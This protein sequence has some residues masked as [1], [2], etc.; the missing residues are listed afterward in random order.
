MIRFNCP[1]CKKSLKAPE[2]FAGRKVVCTRC[3]QRILVPSL[4][5]NKTRLGEPAESNWQD[6]P[7]SRSNG[8]IDA[9]SAN[10]IEEEAVSW[11][12]AEPVPERKRP[13]EKH[14][15]ECGA[16]IRAKAELCPKCG[17]RQPF[18]EDEPVR[19]SRPGR[20]GVKIPLLISAISNILVGL[21]WACTCLG[22]VLTV[23][24]A[25]LCIFEFSLWAKADSLA[26]QD[27]GHRAKNLAIFEIIVGL[28]NTP[29]L[30]CGI[31][32]MINGG[33]MSGYDDDF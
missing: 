13:D 25:I 6:A 17:V 31:I 28:F 7:P 23:P 22:W 2:K 30:I 29:T 32:A 14:C 4:A 12:E 5:V 15:V 11:V 10:P 3:E 27:L 21:I 8:A 1:T 19:M 20:E 33:K 18:M 26:I 16:I 24:M 9:P